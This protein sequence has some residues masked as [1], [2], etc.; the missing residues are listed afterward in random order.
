MGTLGHIVSIGAYVPRLRLPRARI[1]EA[2]G[3]LAA[4]GSRTPEGARAVCNWDEDALTMAVEAAREC[5]RGAPAAGELAGLQ[6][7]ST[8]LPFAD[9]SNATVAAAALDLPE[10]LETLDLGGSMRAG[11]GALAS[12]CGRAA[13]GGNVLVVAS[14][15]RLARPGSEQELAFGAGAAALLV[16]PASARPSEPLATVLAVAHTAADF[17]DHYRLTG[18]DFDY[19]LEERWVR[20]EGYMKLVPAAV[21]RVLEVARI[22]ADRVQRFVLPGSSGAVR[23]LAEACGLRGRAVDALAADC[24]DA[25]CAQPL[26]GLAAALEEALPG[27]HVLVVG[28]GQGVD[29]LVQRVEARAA[30]CVTAA[31][32]RRAEES[33]YVRYLSHSGLLDVDFGM[34]AERDQRSAHSVA[35]R[36]R[37]DVTAFV[38]GRCGACGTVQ[39]PRSRVC[40]NPECRRP[41]T[42]SDH[43]I[44]DSTGRVKSFT[45]DWQAYAARPPYL[46]GNVEL[47]G[48][49]NLLMEFT[50]VESGQLSVGD[51]VRFVFRV[52]DVDRQ[53]RFNRYFW[54]AVP[55]RS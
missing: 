7:A 42:Q 54:K 46:Y 11:T 14:D 8:T 49:G 26:L 19:A 47:E 4:P 37:R 50:D 27:E 18:E 51:A 20:D 5:L 13:G 33:S 9:R 30:P 40:V 34:R 32:A 53:R 3:W 28:F 39:F 24:G 45:E 55:R 15:A 31:L 41:D 16:A 48:G 1:R 35:W 21:K 44:A 25:G 22:D 38:G 52:K 6:L 29:A 2:T 17:V 36:R 10:S 12:A 23:R 43:R